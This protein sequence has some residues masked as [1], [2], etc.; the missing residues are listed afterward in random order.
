MGPF[1]VTEIRDSRAVRLVQLDGVMLHG[2]VNG[3]CLKPFH[4]SKIK[5]K[6]GLRN[7]LASR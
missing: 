4:K 3:A 6:K 1:I 7:E 5:I 2:W